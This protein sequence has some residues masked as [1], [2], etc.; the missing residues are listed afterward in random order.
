MLQPSV[1]ITGVSTG[2]GRATAQLLLERGY[3][4]F[5]SVRR[6]ADADP[7]R[8]FPDFVPLVFDVTDAAGRAAAVA[9]I[10]E[11]GHRLTGLVNNAGIA[12][13]GP[14]ETITEA[15]YRQQFEVNVFGL[16]GVTQAVLPLLHEAREAGEENVTI[17]NVS[18]VSGYVSSPFTSLYSA[19]KF[20]V[21][22]LTDGLRRELLPFGIDVISVAPG[23]VKTP[24]WGKAMTRTE[25]FVGTRYSEVLTKLGPYVQNAESAGIAPALVARIIL[26]SLDSQRPRPDRLVMP[27]SWM[28]RLLRLLPKRTVDK[29]IRKRLDDNRRY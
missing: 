16:L 2:I 15:D 17:V 13:S 7:L 21:E 26:D 4:V 8:R 22:A 23:P 14:L 1:L 27:R 12:V 20:A 11:S 25:P 24:I 5:G 3:H 29:I 10:R 9:A 28:I 18:S 19:S 6:E